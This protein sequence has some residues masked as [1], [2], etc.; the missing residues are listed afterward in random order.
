MR[1]A[2]EDWLTAECAA[3][4]VLVVIEDL[5]WGDL[6]TVSFVDAALRNL[7][8]QRFMVLALARPDIDERF[9]DLWRAR[10]PQVINLGPLSKRASEK[11]VR[12]ALGEVS[13]AV[14]D[15]IVARADGNA[16]YLEELDPRERRGTRAVAARFGAGHGAGAPRRRGQR[17]EARAAGGGRVRRALL[18]DRGGGPAGR[19]RRARR[20]V[21]RDRSPGGARAG[22]ARRHARRRRRTRSSPSRTR[23]C[24][25]PPT[26]C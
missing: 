24:A 20:R 5:H 26:R 13:D 2:W 11:L 15:A 12:G 10:A 19:R 14:V 23:W 22:R 7:R 8:D 4:P 25:R 17:R 6:G 16:F 3:H 21:G 9:P 1:R 18:A